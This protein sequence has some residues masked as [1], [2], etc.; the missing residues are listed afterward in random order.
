MC[1][2]DP[3]GRNKP[4]LEL[5]SMD[6]IPRYKNHL[7]SKISQSWYEILIVFSW[8]MYLFLLLILTKRYG[9]LRRPTSISCGRLQPRLFCPSVQKRH[10]ILF[11]FWVVTL[12]TVSTVTLMIMIL[13][14]NKKNLP[15]FFFNF[16]FIILVFQY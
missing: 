5:R 6:N 15:Q 9:L 8:Q 12:V 16:F 10:V 14:S 1:V 13:K 7:V 11:C 3:C 4:S 2:I